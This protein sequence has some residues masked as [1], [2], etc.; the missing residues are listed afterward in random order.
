MALRRRRGERGPG[1]RECRREPGLLHDVPPRPRPRP[2]SAERVRRLP[3]RP[4][5]L[6]PA[7]TADHPRPLP[8]TLDGPLA[9]GALPNG[10]S[11]RVS[12][13][14]DA[15]VGVGCGGCE[16]Y[17]SIMRRRTPMERARRT[18]PSKPVRTSALRLYVAGPRDVY[19]PSPLAYAVWTAGPGGPDVRSRL[20]PHVRRVRHGYPGPG[21]PH[22]LGAYPAFRVPLQRRPAPHRRAGADRRTRPVD[23]APRPRARTRRTGRAPGYAGRSA[24]RAGDRG[25]FPA[26]ARAGRRGDSGRDGCGG[27]RG[28][29]IRRALGP[30]GERP[31]AS[32][33]APQGHRVTRVG[34]GR[35]RRAGLAPRHPVERVCRAG[36]GVS[37]LRRSTASSS[38][39]LCL[40]N[41]KRTN[42][43]PTSRLS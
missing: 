5:R 12:A 21:P 35:A 41:A 28:W 33:P 29:G 1:S 9:R 24:R 8:S 7:T 3:G 13:A 25:P 11:A 42:G 26:S 18:P 4:L 14:H 20:A 17:G 27:V 15:A 31:H 34:R 23:R 6:P 22:S 36:Q 39:L 16:I 2:E 10:C 32:P 30:R 19:F 37:C 40:Q 43:A 38:T